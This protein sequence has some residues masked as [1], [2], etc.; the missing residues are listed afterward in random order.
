[1]A[2]KITNWTK[3]ADASA[4]PFW[5]GV[6]ASDKYTEVITGGSGGFIDLIPASAPENCKQTE[7]FIRVFK[8]QP[9]A[10]G[11]NIQL[12]ITTALTAGTTAARGFKIGVFGTIDEI[13]EDSLWCRINDKAIG[14]A[15]NVWTH[16]LGTSNSAEDETMSHYN[17][18]G[19]M[20]QSRA[21]AQPVADIATNYEKVGFGAADD[22]TAATN[23]MNFGFGGGTPA[24][25]AIGNYT[26]LVL[27]SSQLSYD[28]IAIR[29][30]GTQTDNLTG[31]ALKFIVKQFN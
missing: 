10:T 17:P 13:S 30:T 26:Q 25:S 29:L 12:H 22:L 28:Y 4:N 1:M 21:N 5:P 15:T 11:M 19:V 24:Q 16:N 7:S 8:V 3:P 18:F 2:M 27:D 20:T 14:G 9:Q 31:G 23:D 6:I